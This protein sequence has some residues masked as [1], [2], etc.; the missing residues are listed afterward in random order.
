MAGVARSLAAGLAASSLM[1][2]VL[3][4]SELRAD[5]LSD[6]AAA[7][8]AAVAEGRTLDAVALGDRFA[9]AVWDASPLAVRK[10]VLV[11]SEPAAFGA[12]T[13]R[14]DN[15]F[16]MD[17]E[18]HLYVEPVAFGWKQTAQGWETDFVADVRIADTSGRIIAAHKSFAEFRIASP[19]PTREVFLAMTYVFGGLGPGDY[20]VTTT[21]HDRIKG[22]AVAFP[23]SIG[24]R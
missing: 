13:P 21:L 6:I 2:A 7:A 19:Q 17:E 14:S 12:D 11:D 9:A 3:M 5:S 8:E 22:D 4:T 16:R 24:I 18:I 20:V 23:T 1:T 15:L 10:A